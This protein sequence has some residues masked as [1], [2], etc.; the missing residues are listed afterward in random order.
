MKKDSGFTFL[1]LVIVLSIVGII[2]IFAIL[3]LN[4][5]GPEMKLS[6]AS[7]KIYVDLMS[8]RME[9]IKQ[10]NKYFS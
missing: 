4:V 8:A 6:G 7:K 3:S 1:E 5:M 9:S 2:A 10:N